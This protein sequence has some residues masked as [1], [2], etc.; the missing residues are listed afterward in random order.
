MW[1]QDCAHTRHALDTARVPERQPAALEGYTFSRPRLSERSGS[2]GVH[3]W[4]VRLDA[5]LLI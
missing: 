5:G 4:V 2:V 1:E 3:E